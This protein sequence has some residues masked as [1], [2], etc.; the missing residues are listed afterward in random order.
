[1]KTFL[2]LLL[3]IL[4]QM[5]VPSPSEAQVTNEIRQMA[6]EAS[7]IEEIDFFHLLSICA[8]ESEGFKPVPERNKH[9]EKGFCQIRE[10]TWKR[11]KCLGNPNS[12]QGTFNCAA[13]LMKKGIKRCNLRASSFPS[14]AF[15]HNTGR[16][17]RRYPK[18]AFISRVR[19]YYDLFARRVIF[20]NRI[21]LAMIGEKK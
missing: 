10:E 9:D 16:C 11:N 20:R 17:P 6:M 15:Y 18:N 14:M 2:L 7:I 5:I 21:T 13:K 12:L 1:M 3:L 4:I 19:F 8:A